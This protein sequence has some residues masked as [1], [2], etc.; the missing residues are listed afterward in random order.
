M[1]NSMQM[2]DIYY[3]ILS[4]NLEFKLSSIAKKQISTYSNHWFAFLLQD[5]DLIC[6]QENERSKGTFFSATLVSHLLINSWISLHAY[7]FSMR[8]S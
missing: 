2:T 1:N 8:I 3:V 5:K 7:L 4:N 6:G